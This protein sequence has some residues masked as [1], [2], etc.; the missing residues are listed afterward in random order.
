[1]RL[2]HFWT[3][4][5]FFIGTLRKLK[6]FLFD[7]QTVSETVLDFWQEILAGLSRLQFTSAE[8]RFKKFSA[9]LSKMI[10]T[11]PEEELWKIFWESYTFF[12]TFGIWVKNCQL[13]DRKISA[14][15]SKMQSECPGEHFE[16]KL[17]FSKEYIFFLIIF[18]LRAIFFKL[19]RD[20]FS[21]V[22]PMAFYV[23]SGRRVWEKILFLNEK[24]T[25]IHLR[26]S[27]TKFGT[28]GEKSSAG[29][30]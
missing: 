24:Y 18:G 4:N 5:Y 8:D 3:S 2:D 6:I 28:S 20:F 29:S 13:F 9:E 14:G 26:N 22:V 27:G 17:L 25:L 23:S 10:F 16:Q 11:C 15:S 21:T 1:M 12:T 30:S 19:W 7:F